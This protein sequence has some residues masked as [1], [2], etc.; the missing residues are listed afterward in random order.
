VKPL[1]ILLVMAQAAFATEAAAQLVLPGLPPAEPARPPEAVQSAPALQPRDARPES[2]APASDVDRREGVWRIEAGY[3]GSYVTSA[4]YNPFSNN[5]Y[6]PEFSLAASRTLFESGRFSFAPGVAWDF[7]G[8]GAPARGDTASLDMQRLTVSLEGRVHLGP[9]GYAYVRAAPGAARQHAQIDEASSPGPLSKTQWVFATDLSAGYAWLIWPR[10]EASAVEPRLW[11]Q[12]EGG[13]GFVTGERLALAPSL[14]SGS[15][16]RVTGVD[17]G[18]L[19]M[20]GGF[21]RVAAA[22]SF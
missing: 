2:M 12:G 3:R 14:P 10:W 8:S 1:T 17:L 16:E 9:W 6:L 20:Q 4:G 19:S 11:L 13:Y 21:F 5:G 7:G 18:S 22:V 15:T